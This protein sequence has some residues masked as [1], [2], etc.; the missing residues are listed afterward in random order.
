[1]RIAPA[2]IAAA[3]ARVALAALPPSSDEE[4]AKAADTAAKAA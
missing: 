4:K 1:M 3:Y 2:L